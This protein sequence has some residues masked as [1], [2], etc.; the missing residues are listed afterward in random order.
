MGNSEFCN[1][2]D[3]VEAVYEYAILGYVTYANSRY[4]LENPSQ[5]RG[6]GKISRNRPCLRFEL[7]FN[8]PTPGTCRVQTTAWGT[9]SSLV[10]GH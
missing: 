8:E 1:K 10:V 7:K 3:S 5:G 9:T 4:H 6:L 2:M